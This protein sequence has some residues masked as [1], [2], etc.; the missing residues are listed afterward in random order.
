MSPLGFQGLQQVLFSEQALASAPD[1]SNTNK[2]VEFYLNTL[3][4]YYENTFFFLLLNYVF[5][6]VSV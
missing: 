1:I 6:P 4:F 3:F 5:W 2:E